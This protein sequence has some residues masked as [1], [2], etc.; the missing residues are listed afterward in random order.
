MKSRRVLLTS[1]PSGVAQAENFAIEEAE[2]TPLP[3]GQIRVRNAFLSVEPAMRGWIADKG[4]YSAPV[5]IG[6]VMRALAVGEVV[7]SR[8]REFRPGEIVTGWFGWQDYADVAALRSGPPRQRDG[9]SAFPRARR[10]R[11]QRRHRPD[12]AGGHRRAEGRRHRARLDGGR[13]RRIGGRADRQDPRMPDG[14]RRGR[15]GQGRDVPR[16]FRL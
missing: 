10:P 15:P 2:L 4:N 3:E 11:H 1:R 8:C 5:E 7:E 16:P 9:P 14:R 13:G 12:R 6:S